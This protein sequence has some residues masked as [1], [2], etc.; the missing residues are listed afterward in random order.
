MGITQYHLIIS[1]QVQGVSYRFSACNVATDLGLTGWVSNRID[2]WVEIVAEGDI[3]TL[4]QLV[5]WA[6]KGPSYANVSDVIVEQR[7]ATGD[8]KDFMIR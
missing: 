5:I 2:G 6:K 7:T 3:A 1:G 4:E 8:F